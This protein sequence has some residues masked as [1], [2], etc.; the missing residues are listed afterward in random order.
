MLPELGKN[1][2]ERTSSGQNTQIQLSKDNRENIKE[3]NTGKSFSAKKVR[4]WSFDGCRT[5]GGFIKSAP[6]DKYSKETINDIIQ[7]RYMVK[8]TRMP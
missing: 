3:A 1:K 8:F 4:Y 6:E 2:K 7:Q 5:G